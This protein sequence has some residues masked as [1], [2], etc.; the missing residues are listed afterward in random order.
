VIRRVIVFLLYVTNVHDT[1]ILDQI[2]HAIWF[3]QSEFLGAVTT[4]SPPDTIHHTNETPV[5]NLS[6]FS[7]R[8]RCRHFDR[9]FVMF[10]TGEIEDRFQ[11]VS[12]VYFL[13]SKILRSELSHI[14]SCMCPERILCS[15]LWCFMSLTRGSWRGNI[16]LF[17]RAVIISWKSDFQ[18]L[19]PYSTCFGMFYDFPQMARFHANGYFYFFIEL[20]PSHHLGLPSTPN[21]PIIWFF[22]PSNF[23]WQ[24]VGFNHT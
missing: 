13:I 22:W 1:Q 18:F 14:T 23:Q 9:H 10:H 15:S 11:E 20:L 3:N 21:T 6:G 2:L 19:L 16:T 17:S 12:I 7:H 8:Y 4:M 24:N 5:G